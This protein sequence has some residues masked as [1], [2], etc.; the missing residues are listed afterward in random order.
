MKTCW[1]NEMKIHSSKLPT[2]RLVNGSTYLL[3]LH[4]SQQP[5]SAIACLAL[6]PKRA[7]SNITDKRQDI[8]YNTAVKKKEKLC[9]ERCTRSVIKLVRCRF[10][11]CSR[12]ERNGRELRVRET[13]SW[14]RELLLISFNLDSIG[15]SFSPPSRKYTSAQKK[16]F[17][18]RKYKSEIFN[19]FSLSF[20]A[21]EVSAKCIKL[22]YI[23]ELYPS[24]RHDARQTTDM[25]NF[26]FWMLNLSDLWDLSL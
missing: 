3:R 18:T 22:H 8:V 12:V 2:R 11:R 1:P 26:L 15:L 24:Y 19:F 21:G 17:R 9:R 16:Q 25:Q 4:S 6:Q 7:H 23:P 13:V 5:T 20:R 10:R 14:A